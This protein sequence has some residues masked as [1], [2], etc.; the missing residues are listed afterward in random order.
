VEES[1]STFLKE[2]R[3]VGEEVNINNRS[4][5]IVVYKIAFLSWEAASTV[6]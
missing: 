4:K 2:S 5:I 1:A 3:E 6:W